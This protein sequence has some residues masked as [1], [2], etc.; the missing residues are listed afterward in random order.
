MFKSCRC[1]PSACKSCLSVCIRSVT[2]SSPHQKGIVWCTQ[3]W[4][5]FIFAI[6]LEPCY[7][8]GGTLNFTSRF[9]PLAR[10]GLYTPLCIPHSKHILTKGS[11]QGNKQFHGGAY[12]DI[13]NA[14]NAE[15]AAGKVGVNS[16]LSGWNSKYKKWPP[17]SSTAPFCFCVVCVGF[18][19]WFFTFVTWW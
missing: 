16:L 6:I 9:R 4:A 5:K 7:G 3:W 10:V 15:A 14:Q 19:W 13:K 1:T 12:R 8:R 17:Y 11:V 18:V 2:W